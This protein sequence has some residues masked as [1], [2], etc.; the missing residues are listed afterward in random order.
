MTLTRYALQPPQT[1]WSG[2]ERPP[3]SVSCSSSLV[4]QADPKLPTE[5]VKSRGLQSSPQH[6]PLEGKQRA[7]R[8]QNTHDSFQH[9]ICLRVLGGVN[10]T[11][12][13]DEED[14][15]HQGNVLPDLKAE[16]S[17]Y[18][19]FGSVPERGFTR[20]WCSPDKTGGWGS[21]VG[22]VTEGQPAR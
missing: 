7:S 3:C 2:A 14:P 15:T 20:P 16:T 21:G 5:W 1:G 13:V 10:H 18:D 6:A 17:V 19:C 12:T 22:A 11:R 9:N 8:D 4:R